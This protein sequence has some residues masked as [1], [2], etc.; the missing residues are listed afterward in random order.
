MSKPSI[1]AAKQ[2]AG[3]PCHLYRG[4]TVGCVRVISLLE[5]K[6][7]WKL[8]LVIRKEAVEDGGTCDAWVSR[9]AEL[10]ISRE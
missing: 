1:D 5:L 4:E 2:L 3:V 7:K 10:A 8:N 9:E 6:K